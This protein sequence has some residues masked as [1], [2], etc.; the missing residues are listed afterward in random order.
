MR[1]ALIS[2]LAGLALCAVASQAGAQD[3]TAPAEQPPATPWCQ[4]VDPT[5][6]SDSLQLNL[7][8]VPSEYAQVKARTILQ[9][10]GFVELTKDMAADLGVPAQYVQPNAYLVRAGGYFQPQGVP[11]RNVQAFYD[12]GQG[13]LQV[14]SYAD[15][16]SS[17]TSNWA[18]IVVAAGPISQERAVCSPTG[19]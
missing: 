10:E 18:A 8:Y 6:S 7:V 12:A 3:Y 14:N 5:P 2:G 15:T 13:M 9:V 1:T 17:V 19:G 16:T 4:T 11:D